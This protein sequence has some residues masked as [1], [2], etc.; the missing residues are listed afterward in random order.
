MNDA[1]MLIFARKPLPGRVKTRLTPPLSPEEA[2]ALY[3]AMVLDV[4]D[5]CRHITVADQLLCYDNRPGTREFF[6]P[7][8][9][10]GALFPQEGDG[11]GERLEHAFSHAFNRGYRRVVVIGTDSPD[12][13][14]RYIRDAFRL[15]EDGPQKAVFGPTEDGGYYLLGLTSPQPLLFRDIPWSTDRVLE[16]SLAKCSEAGL[17]TELL[18]RWHDLDTAADLKRLPLEQSAPAAPHTCNAVAALKAAGRL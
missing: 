5:K 13:P 7:L 6:T 9:G 15:L 10:D 1:A 18:P 11:L 2:A 4:L 14:A 16:A 12:L 3:S 8:L 17:R